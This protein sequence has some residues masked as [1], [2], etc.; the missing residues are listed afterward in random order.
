MYPDVLAHSFSDVS[1]IYMVLDSDWWLS[2]HYRHKT[3][4][5]VKQGVSM[6]SMGVEEKNV[7]GYSYHGSTRQ[8]N[9]TDNTFVKGEE[10]ALNAHCT[11]T[12]LLKIS[13]LFIVK[14][15]FNVSYE[16]RST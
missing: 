15:Y 16:V 11:R 3:K 10:I 8:L 13:K 2:R 4:I 5:Y 9:K 7:N 1:I 12:N 14:C 6:N